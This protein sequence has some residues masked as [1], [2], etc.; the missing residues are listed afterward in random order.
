MAGR[1]IRSAEAARDLDGVFGDICLNNGWD[2]AVAQMERLEKALD[3]LG[4]FPRLGRRR[5]DL[6]GGPF[7]FPV[8]P[9]T[10]FYEISGADVRVL[11][12]IDRRR[13]FGSALRGNP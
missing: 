10:I 5:T 1:V 9:W 6:K 12:I 11:R 2:V 4:D 13:D 8:S 3:R 7:V